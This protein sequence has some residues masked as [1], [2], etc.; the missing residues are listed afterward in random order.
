MPRFFTSLNSFQTFCISASPE[1]LVKVAVLHVFDDQQRRL[2]DR[3]AVQRDDVV[4]PQS[5]EKLRFA[6]EVA[7]A[8]VVCR[9][10]GSHRQLG[11]LDG[12]R[13]DVTRRRK[14]FTEAKVDRPELSLTQLS[15]QLHTT[16]SDVLHTAY[17]NSK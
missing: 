11:R 9:Q 1:K 10:T 7:Q 5:V 6:L 2:V 17:R 4:V 12:D 16:P 15:H 8:L 14:L 3:D 13:G